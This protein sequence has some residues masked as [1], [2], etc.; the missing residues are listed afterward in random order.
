[1]RDNVYKFFKKGPDDI[2][3]FLYGYKNKKFYKKDIDPKLVLVSSYI[4]NAT[5]LIECEHVDSKFVF[6]MLKITALIFIGYHNLDIQ[7]ELEKYW[8]VPLL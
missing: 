5:S 2:I 8:I 3:E 1:M 4:E 7:E 6:R